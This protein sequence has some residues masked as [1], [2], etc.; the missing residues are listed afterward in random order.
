MTS[1]RAF[2]W[3][4]RAAFSLFTLLIVCLRA[5]A[6]TDP[7]PSWNEGLAKQAIVEFVKATTERASSQFVPPEAR[8]ATFDQDGTTWVEHPIYTQVV[9]CLE[10]VPALVIAKPELKTVEPFKTVLSGNREAMA[11][12]SMQDL[13][14]ILAATL[15]GMFRAPARNVIPVARTSAVPAGVMFGPIPNSAPSRVL[16]PTIQLTL[17]S[18]T[19][20]S[21][22]PTSATHSV[23]IVTPL[24]FV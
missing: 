16:T 19:L 22:P 12:L 6:Q 5:H 18:T 13:E 15:T 8:V 7:L 9:Y 3:P 1:V 23:T 10:R 4:A 17:G 20:C 2:V 24:S 21:S 11:K 14:K